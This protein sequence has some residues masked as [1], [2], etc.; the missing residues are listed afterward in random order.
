MLWILF[1]SL[2]YFFLSWTTS[3]SDLETKSF[4]KMYLKYRKQQYQ[5]DN[6][7]LPLWQ[8]EWLSPPYLRWVEEVI[9]KK[10]YLIQSYKFLHICFFKYF[11][12]NTKTWQYNNLPVQCI[13]NLADEL[14]LHQLQVVTIVLVLL[15]RHTELSL[16]LITSTVH[17]Q[18]KTKT[19]I[20]RCSPR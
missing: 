3:L 4:L 13:C 20:N 6:H 19:L 16:A 10:K 11:V 5:S 12:T 18:N 8:S 17:L 14:K 9:C 1:Q 2:I 15:C 7:Y